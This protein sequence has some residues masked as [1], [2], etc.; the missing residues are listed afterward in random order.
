VVFKLKTSTGPCAYQIG[1]T[2]DHH[3]GIQPSIFFGLVHGSFKLL[4]LPPELCQLIEC[5]EH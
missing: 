4:E 3:G 5:I 1:Q 2:I